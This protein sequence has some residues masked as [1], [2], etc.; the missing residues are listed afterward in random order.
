METK[1]E[2]KIVVY[3]DSASDCVEKYGQL[4][5]PIRFFMVNTEE[6]MVKRVEDTIK[7]GWDLNREST[8]ERIAIEIPRRVLALGTPLDE[9][10]ES[11]PEH[12]VPEADIYFV[13]GLSGRK[14][15]SLGGVLARLPKEK[16]VINSGDTDL[17]RELEREGYRTAYPKTITQSMLE[18]YRR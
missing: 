17:V 13:D 10:I 9:F 15:G 7:E 14:Y 12:Q 3:E 18:G 4:R 5:R 1:T 16:V 8:V 6:Y 2:P 11:A